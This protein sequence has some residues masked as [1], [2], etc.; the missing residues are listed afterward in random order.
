MSLTGLIE[1]LKR[2]PKFVALIQ[3]SFGLGAIIVG[4][5]YLHSLHASGL[6]LLPENFE[7]RRGSMS[8]YRSVISIGGKS[9][10]TF[11]GHFSIAGQTE[12]YYVAG[13]SRELVLD[14][15]PKATTVSC[16]LRRPDVFKLD[17][18]GEHRCFGFAVDDQVMR[19]LEKAIANQK[20]FDSILQVAC[21]G[22]AVA[23]VWLLSIG[24]LRL[25]GV[26]LQ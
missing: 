14:D 6:L 5:F 18:E 23:G 19:S 17:P 11:Q 7:E 4:L 16:T 13:F 25:C 2:Y 3:V 20:F 1:W 24:V 22:F 10:S 8:D 21:I 15:F 9:A 26:V 12:H